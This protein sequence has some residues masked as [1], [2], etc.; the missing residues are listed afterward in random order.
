MPAWDIETLPKSTLDS[1]MRS[2]VPLFLLALTLLAGQAADI[3]AWK[4]PVS[5]YASGDWQAEGAVRLR[6][7]P[8]ESPFFKDGHAHGVL[9]PRLAA[10]GGVE[11][12]VPLDQLP[13]DLLRRVGVDRRARGQPEDVRRLQSVRAHRGEPATADVVVDDLHPV[14]I[15]L[16]LT[17]RA[18]P[19]PR[20]AA[21][22]GPFAARFVVNPYRLGRLLTLRRGPALAGP[23]AAADSSG[24]H[25]PA[26]Q[27]R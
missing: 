14:S 24:C 5:R 20:L 8:E 18:P 27:V 9:D 16:G 6:S 12:L 1:C 13:E 23:F 15:P 2:A 3:V 17:P 19:R 25:V 11:I 26:D 4:V 21:L 7:A 10:G 22:A